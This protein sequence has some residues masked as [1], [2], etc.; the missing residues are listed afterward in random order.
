MK[1]FLSLMLLIAAC[2]T[3]FAQSPDPYAKKLYGELGIGAASYD[4]FAVSLGGRTILPS[5]WTFAL[6]YHYAELDPK[7]LP[8]DYQPANFI[9]VS[10]GNPNVAMRMFGVTAGRYFPAGR[11]FWFTAEA[12][13][14]VVSGKEFQFTRRPSSGA[15]GDAF[16][17]NYTTTEETKITIGA[18]ARADANFAVASFMGLGIGVCQCQRPSVASR[19]SAQTD[20]W[21]NE[22]I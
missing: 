19:L 13:P 8:A 15:I 14:S 10:E 4:A 21:K 7:N 20:S 22:H 12:G 16:N 3:A 17:S 5:R 1:Q 9:F 6:S 18:M 11:K 2:Q